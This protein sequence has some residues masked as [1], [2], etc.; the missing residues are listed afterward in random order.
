MRSRY[1]FLAAVPLV[2]AFVGTAVTAP[3]A[4]EKPDAPPTKEQLGKS[5]NNLKEI[6]LAIHNF[7]DINNALPS[8]VVK[9]G[10]VILSWRIHLLPYLE[11]DDLFKQFKLD[12]PWDSANNKKLIEKIPDVYAP[13]RGKA[14]KAATYY[15][16]FAGEKGLLRPG[17]KQTSFANITDGLSNTFMV[18]EAAKPVIWTK[19]GDIEYDE[20]TVPKLGGMFGPGFTN[21]LFGDGSVGRLLE[22]AD[23]VTMQR[24]INPA[25]GQVVD[26]DKAV[27]RNVP[28]KD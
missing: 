27:D 9:D 15:Q 10:K 16:M 20:K 8:N 1:A 17:G 4:K 11:Q 13:L 7:H 24:L 25:D 5:L 21:V 22:V 18:I 28:V 6:G 12:E 19:P 26:A 3:A 14:E 2:A 23:D